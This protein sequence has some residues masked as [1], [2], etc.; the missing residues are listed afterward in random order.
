MREANDD[1][2]VEIGTVCFSMSSP[3][4]L[5]CVTLQMAV[6]NAELSAE[7]RDGNG[8]NSAHYINSSTRWRTPYLALQQW[9]GILSNRWPGTGPAD[10]ASALF[11]GPYLTGVMAPQSSAQHPFAKWHC[12]ATV[13]TK[14][15]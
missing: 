9:V 14:L 2:F 12:P 11:N 13:N 6:L 10:R 5:V 4:G 7:R 15:L 3:M 8:N 1:M